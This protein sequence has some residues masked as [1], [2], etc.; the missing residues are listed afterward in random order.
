MKKSDFIYP[1]SSYYGKGTPE[2]IEF[3]KKLQDYSQKLSYISAFQ[4]AGKISA[5]AAYKQA[6]KLWQELEQTKKQLDCKK[7]TQL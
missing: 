6:E 3:N 4:T 7:T 1:K 5:I 2:N